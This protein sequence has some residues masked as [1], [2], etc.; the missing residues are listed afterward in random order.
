M[1]LFS[2]KKL[3]SPYHFGDSPPTNKKLYWVDDNE[4]QPI[5]RYF[6]LTQNNWIP[7]GMN[8]NIPDVKTGTTRPVDDTGIWIKTK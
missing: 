2:K 7:I 4:G 1:S 5:L 3:S 8:V 6:D